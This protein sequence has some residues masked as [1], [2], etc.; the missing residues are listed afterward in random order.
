MILAVKGKKPSYTYE[1]AWGDGMI[2]LTLGLVSAPFL[3]ILGLALTSRM[4]RAV[5]SHTFGTARRKCSFA[6][7]KVMSR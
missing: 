1:S 5:P 7:G 3:L 6:A 4:S 2:K